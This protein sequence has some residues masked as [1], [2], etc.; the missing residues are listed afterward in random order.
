MTPKDQ[1]NSIMNCLGGRST[2][3]LVLVLTI[4]HAAARQPLIHNQYIK[5][6]IWDHQCQMVIVLVI[7]N[8]QLRRGLFS[9]NAT[10]SVVIFS[11]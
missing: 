10:L 5:G 9:V 4:Q 2:N 3:G 8:A 1:K 6:A 11:V 7:D